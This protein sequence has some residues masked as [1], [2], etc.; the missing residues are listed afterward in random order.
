M[1]FEPLKSLAGYL[2]PGDATRYCFVVVETWDTYE[3]A[4]LNDS[5]AD[6]LTFLKHT[7]EYYDS[8]RGKYT[9]P[10]TI[11]A[12]EQ[13]IEIYLEQKGGDNNEG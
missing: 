4:V 10:W 6:K 8:T 13:M 9:N 2:E 7:G 11:K 12:A 1:T 3:V 5:F